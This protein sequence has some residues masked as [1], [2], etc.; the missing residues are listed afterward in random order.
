MIWDELTTVELSDVDR[1]CVVILPLAAT[2]QHGPH[3]PLATDRLIAEG[4][5]REL[6]K[7]LLE[8]TLI[9]PCPPIGYS[10][11]HR[12]FVGTLSVS[13][14][15]LMDY[16]KGVI[17]SVFA[18]G[19]RSLLIMNA[20]GGNVGLGTVLQE[21]IGEQ[22]PSNDLGFC[23]WWQVAAAELL[24]ISG[25]GPGGV[26][27]ACEL[28]TSLMLHLHPELVK[29]DR[30]QS[31][32]NCPTWAWAEA[33]MLRGSRVR[34]QRSMKQMTRNGVYGDPTCADGVKG[35]QILDVVINN[36]KTVVEDLYSKQ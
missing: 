31:G 27:H 19:F 11:H 20:H 25:S 1:R 24:D 21:S 8:K 4:F 35:K 12:S 2:E 26:G 3:L 10:A 15:T 9:L 5:C 16:A 7:Q 30:I 18:D 29:L 22:Y 33:D 32:T 17:E 34:L 36:L 14:S 23:S 13:H 28:E 6:N